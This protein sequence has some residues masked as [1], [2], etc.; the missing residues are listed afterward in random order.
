[1]LA[2]VR[3]KNYKEIKRIQ[4]PSKEWVIKQLNENVCQ[5]LFKKK[6]NGKFRSLKCTRSFKTLPRKY[7]LQDIDNIQ[8]PHGYS[9]IIPVWD[10]STRDWK[11]FYYDTVYVFTVLLGEI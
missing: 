2:I 5:I 7:K 4:Q 8:N 11:S 6:L 3:D 1:M 10:I 9:D